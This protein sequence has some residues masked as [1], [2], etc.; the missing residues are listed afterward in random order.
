MY[1]LSFFSKMHVAQI[2]GFGE[3]CTQGSV[4]LS[5]SICSF[6]GWL[7]VL[8]SEMLTFGVAESWDDRELSMCLGSSFDG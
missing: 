6:H 3:H 2:D 5:L 7:E 8:F 4:S 1:C